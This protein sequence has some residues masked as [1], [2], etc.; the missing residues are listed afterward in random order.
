VQRSS[1]A[2]NCDGV[3]GASHSAKRLFELLDPWPLRQPIAPEALHDGRNIVLLNPLSAVR[4]SG[5]I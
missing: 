5:Q 3:V 1:A 2:T 4:E